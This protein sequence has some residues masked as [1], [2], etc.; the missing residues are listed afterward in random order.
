MKP[1]LSLSKS[2]KLFWPILTKAQSTAWSE[3]DN[4]MASHMCRDLATVEE[5]AH[6]DCGEELL[7]EICKRIYEGSQLLKL[8][9][10]TGNTAHHKIVQTIFAGI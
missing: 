6:S 1:L 5:L 8:N 10:V 2:E 9:T 4:I 7:P 3:V